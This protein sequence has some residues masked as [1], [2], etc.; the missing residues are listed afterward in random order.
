MTPQTTGA[1][2]SHIFTAYVWAD[3][4]PQVSGSATVNLSSS[5]SI[6]YKT[7]GVVWRPNQNVW[8]S[9]ALP[10]G[11]NG[12]EIFNSNGLLL[13]DIGPGWN[14][15]GNVMVA[16]QIN[17]IPSGQIPTVSTNSA[18]SISQN[19]ATLNSSVNPN[20]SNTNTWFEYGTT[21]SLG[22][23]VGYQ[24]VGSGNSSTNISYNLS[25]L[26]SSTTYYYRLVASNSYGTSYGSILSFIT[27][28]SIPSGQIPT[29]STNS[30][31]SISQNSATLNSSVN[32]NNS[33]TN[34]WFE[35]GTTQ[36]LGYT[37]GYQSVG[38]GNS[39]TNISYNLSGLQ[40]STTYYYRLVASN[41]YGTSY[42]SIMNFYTTGS[43]L[44]QTG[45]A[46]LVVTKNASPVYQ[47][48]ALFNGSVNP[49]GGL[50]TAWFE[51]GTNSNS[52][53]KS[54]VSQPMGIGTTYYDLSYAL[55]G[56]STNTTYYYRAVAQNLYGAIYGNILNFTTQGS[57]VAYVQEAPI[58]IYK[59]ITAVAGITPALIQRSITL[60]PSVD[61]NQP[62]LGDELNYSVI[63]K[64][65]LDKAVY[66]VVLKITL[67]FEV[68]YQSVNLAPTSQESNNLIFN[69]GTISGNSQGMISVKVK[70]NKFAEEGDI[71]IFT[72]VAD[73]NDAK[74]NFQ[75]TSAY[76]TINVVGDGSLFALLI[77]SISDILGNWLFWLI[78]ILIAIAVL[79]YYQF[80]K[81]ES[82]A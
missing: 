11:Q 66:D 50:T 53:P 73:Y 64:N 22:Y 77:N 19:S 33:N 6:S 36:S 72:S 39:S 3:N 38:S 41:S 17:S 24:S 43:G 12:S 75:S 81:N 67:P 9:Q 56:L 26:Q 8:G 44:F 14:T 60:L 71:L 1:G 4:A 35:Y 48:S 5:Q 55:S 79:F 62:S 7:N 78:A 52:L 51:W 30:A 10:N 20:N 76:L 16:Y 40:S 25:G 47:N 18:S 32:P 45:S 23:T 58:V 82:T 34:T 21:Q 2:T 37:V 63:Y 57:Q 65:V 61:K 28:T 29:V 27:Q 13:G 80:F 54:T 69:L 74:N 70:L 46:P 49:R 31:S 59:T 68:D 42:G 15:Q